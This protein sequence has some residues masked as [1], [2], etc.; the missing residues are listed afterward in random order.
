[1]GKCALLLLLLCV[2]SP[3][4]A[5]DGAP[6]LHGRSTLSGPR[7]QLT[8]SDQRWLWA[9]R[10]LRLGVVRPDKPPFD[11][12]GTGRQYE[13]IS[14]DYAQL[15]ALQLNLTIEVR[16]YDTYSS[17]VDALKAGEVD[18]L[19]SVTAT[20]A[21]QAG[22]RLSQAYA[23]D[24]PVLASRD[25]SPEVKG[26]V[27]LAMVQGYRS[28]EHV[29]Q[30]YP[31]AQ[32]LTFPST[33]GAMAAVALG[34]ADLYLG[35]AQASWHQLARRQFD[36]LKIEGYAA[37]PGQPI[38]FAVAEQ[39][40]PLPRLIN[41]VLVSIDDAQHERI[42]RRWNAVE[43]GWRDRTRIALS[44]A[45]QRW[46]DSNPRVRVVVDEHFLPFSYR[47][48]QGRHRGLSIDLLQR[49]GR[50]TGLNFEIIQGGTMAQMIEQLRQGDVQVMAVSTPSTLREKQLSFTRAYFSTARV[51]VTRDSP[52]APSRLEQLAGQRLALIHGS[53]LEDYLRREFP[54][55][56]QVVAQSPVE[57]LRLVAQGQADG[58]VLA[59]EAARYL[60]ARSYPEH[61]KVSAALAL[62]PVHL[63][64]ATARGARELHSILDKALLGLTP[65]ELGELL[66]GGRNEVI[67]AEGFWP[68]LRW[69][70]LQGSAVA[71]VVVLLALFW[72]RALRRQVR[73]R[74]QAERVLADQLDFMREM[75]DRMPHPIYVCDDKGRLLACN[76]SYLETL[77]VSLEAVIGQPVG[78]P[79]ALAW[80]RV[81]REVLRTGQVSVEDCQVVLG[82]GRQMTLNHWMLPYRH[83]RQGHV[84]V[85]AG[86]I[87]VTDRQRL[88]VSLQGAKQA[89]ERANLAKTHFLA[90]MSH[91]IRTPMNALLGMLEL[92][93]RKA[94][95]GVADR[96]SIEVASDAARG[97]LSLVGDIL[98]VSRIEAGQLQLVPRRTQV[99]A[100]V[101]AVVRLFEQQARD[102]GVALL[103]DF[104]GQVDTQLML[105]PMRFRQVLGNV[106]SNAL[107]FTPAGHVRVRLGLHPQGERL[108]LVMSV[109]DT[110]IGIPPA[111]LAQLGEAFRQASNCNQSARRGS[112]LGLNISRTLCRLMGGSLQLHSRLGVG[113]RV[114]VKLLLERTQGEGDE[115]AGA[116]CT[117]DNLVQAR[118]RVLVVEDY[119]P[120]RL[121]LV[122]QLEYLGHE[123]SVAEEGGQALRAFLG[124]RFDVVI[125]DCNMPGLDGYALVRAIRLHE[126]RRQAPPCLVLGITANALAAERQRC[127]AVG[128]NDCLFKPLSLE[129]LAD[130]LDRHTPS[131]QR[132]CPPDGAFESL[133]HLARG[134]TLAA[135]A[136]LEDL[137]RSNRQDLKQL[138]LALRVNDQAALMSLAHRIK[139]GA[140]MIRA[141]D[142]VAV[143]EALE[144]EC[145]ARRGSADGVR[146]HGL[147]VRDAI[148]ALQASL[149]QARRQLD[150]GDRAVLGSYHAQQQQHQKHHQHDAEDP[151]GAIAPASRV[152]EN[153]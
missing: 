30:L 42:Q 114:E 74:E 27:R 153:R 69:R 29:T 63:A 1:V 120:N 64:L 129:A 50:M 138:M 8:D 143:C 149:L 57:A 15:I 55:I 142:L 22:V 32:V 60:V 106:L 51:L 39:N 86:W 77:G 151:R 131:Q 141:G 124:E 111:E 116:S 40:G 150:A 45:E 65:Q 125:S 94:R 66:Q 53:A 134:N 107:K 79:E 97:L 135:R 80:Q 128:M 99:R 118:L 2:L 3:V 139:G 10:Q 152:G 85:L 52:Q 122:Q 59:L 78:E 23:S 89:A 119:P 136:L 140:R 72:I 148:L 28:V 117:G 16:T 18:L 34:Q 14:A 5:G 54:Q 25:G 44:T 101:E 133:L 61:L 100:E 62:E 21:Q 121:L 146:H 43:P 70:I 96:L 47:D 83:Q 6:R 144:R 48:A 73:L 58:A 67:V 56:E 4:V 9:H 98:D 36:N 11:I 20:Q 105:D 126:S 110:G 82:N 90:T 91:E 103:M 13:G 87:D 137:L 115:P 41:R 31:Q 76:S 127:L 112:G 46:L 68:R 17:A 38:G 71:S 108:A 49:I 123:V 12:L 75:I 81:W 84:G 33:L 130:G 19:S 24:W 35:N 147:S 102:K 113:T 7:L 95:Q 104:Q 92:S 88:Q 93:L 132:D 145:A 109:E 26:P 37:V